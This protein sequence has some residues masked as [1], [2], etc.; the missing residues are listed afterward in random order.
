MLKRTVS[1]IL[2]DPPCK[3]D[4]VRFTTV[5][6]KTLSGQLLIEYPCFCESKLFIFVCIFS[7]KSD[8]RISCFQ[9]SMEKFTEIN[10][11]QVKKKCRI[12]PHF[13]Q[14]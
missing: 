10:T 12:L 1:V 6:L 14:I 3:E 2:I 5:P 11:V 8:L 9:E 7:A 13:Y 4:N